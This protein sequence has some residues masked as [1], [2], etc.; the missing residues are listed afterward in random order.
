[1][2]ATLER[3]ETALAEQRD[4]AIRIGTGSLHPGDTYP[5]PSAEAFEIADPERGKD[6]EPQYEDYLLAADV[7]RLAASLIARHPEDFKH[8]KGAKIAYRWKRAGGKTSGKVKYGTCRRLDGIGRHF[9]SA[10]FLIWL[11]ADNCRA[12]RMTAH[13]IEAL[14]YHELL[15]IGQS[16]GDEPRLVLVPHDFEGFGRELAVYGMWHHDLK[17]IGRTLQM[18]LFEQNGR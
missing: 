11:A 18:P 4:L 6:D 14:T 5:V 15:H 1:M 2:T 16:D 10:D 8:L 3:N 13:T 12:Q 17:I 7:E 9:A